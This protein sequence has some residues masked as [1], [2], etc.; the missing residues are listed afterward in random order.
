MGALSYAGQFNLMAVSDTDAYPD[1]D[2]FLA[3]AR[4]EFQT[5]GEATAA[6]EVDSTEA[7]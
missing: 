5:L 6:S 2:V 7:Q 3:G 1:L 4:D